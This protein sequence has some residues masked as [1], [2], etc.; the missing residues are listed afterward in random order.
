RRPPPSGSAFWVAARDLPPRRWCSSRPSL[1]AE[2]RTPLDSRWLVWALAPP[3]ALG[4]PVVQGLLRVQP[5]DF[6]VEEP[7]GFDPAGDGSHALLRARKRGCNT[8][9]V[10]R[11]L[12]R[13]AGCRVAEV[14]FA[15]LK[16]RH[17]VATQW[18]SVPLG[19]AGIERWQALCGAEFEVLEA[20][21]HT[22]K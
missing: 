7:L 15:G 19:R 2:A 13:H 17:A 3:R 4:E 18:Y 5:E 8:Q 20:H 10:A 12:A 11:E 21:P 16:D 9:W 14:G 6:W 22:R 1:S